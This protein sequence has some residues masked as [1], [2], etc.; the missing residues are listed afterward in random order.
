MYEDQ[1]TSTNFKN[2]TK[3]H[4]IKILVP[5]QIRGEKIENKKLSTKKSQ[6]NSIKITQPFKYA[7]PF[8]FSE[9]FC[10]RGVYSPPQKG[11]CLRDIPVDPVLLPTLIPQISR[12][13]GGVSELSS[14]LFQH[15]WKLSQLPS[16]GSLVGAGVA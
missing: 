13:G 5:T 4:E 3:P 16:Y 9:S 6:H 12:R 1:L 8:R 2:E 15:W 10:G 14:L 7:F 11:E